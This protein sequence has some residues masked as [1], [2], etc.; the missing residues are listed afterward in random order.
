MA[1]TST[2]SSERLITLGAGCIP[3]PERLLIAH[4]KGQ[5]LFIT[6]AGTSLA[7]GLPDFRRLVLLVYEKLDPAVSAVLEKVPRGCSNQFEADCAGLTPRQCA[8]VQRFIVGDYDVVL[9]LLERRLDPVGEPETSVRKAIDQ[10]IRSGAAKPAPIHLALLRLADRGGA[11]TIITTNF[12]LLLE[13]A[14]RSQKKSLQAYSLGAIPRPTRRPDF[15]GIFHIH[16]ALEQREAR[17]ADLI[18]SDHDFGEFYLRRRAI[19]DFI[20]DAAR[21]FHIVLVGYSANDPPMRYLLNAVA[22]DGSRFDDLKERFTF[23]GGHVPAHPPAIEDWKGRGITPIPYDEADDHAALAT[24]LSKWAEL[25]AVTGQRQKI[26]ALLKRIV[27]SKRGDAT[28]ADR[29]LFDHL[30][31]RAEPNERRRLVRI[32]S[33]E[34]ADISWL[35]AVDKISGEPA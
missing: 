10:V 4:A 17:L 24:T 33:Q 8:E 11:T 27:R 30:I 32:A 34:K 16:G 6:G 13:Q 31:R 35:A 19:P 25:S 20:Y 1:E 14:A 23:S 22:A 28:D 15:A 18:V 5:V 7:A 3:I 9:G 29:D 26:D 21:L 2:F 12:D